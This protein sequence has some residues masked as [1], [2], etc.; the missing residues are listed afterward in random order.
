MYVCDAEVVVD[1]PSCCIQRQN[2]NEVEWCENMEGAYHL[3]CT[4]LQ[5]NP[6]QCMATCSV[7][8]SSAVVAV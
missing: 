4:Y 1:V 6:I 8:S 3:L 5:F 2:M 7:S